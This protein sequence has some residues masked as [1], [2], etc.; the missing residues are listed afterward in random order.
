MICDNCWNNPRNNPFAT[1]FCN[2]ALPAM[3]RDGWGSKSEKYGEAITTS[4]I[5]IVNYGSSKKE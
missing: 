5:T 1:G 2:C 3:E 4:C